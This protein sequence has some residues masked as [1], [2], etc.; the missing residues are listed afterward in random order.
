MGK[1]DTAVEHRPIF[2]PPIIR[3]DSPQ[4]KPLAREGRDAPD[5]LGFGRHVVV[6]IHS[7]AKGETVRQSDCRRPR[8][9][10][11]TRP[12]RARRQTAD[13]QRS[14]TGFNPL[15][16]EG[17]DAHACRHAKA[18]D[19]VSIHSPAKGETR[20]DP[21]VDRS[22]RVSIHSPAKGETAKRAARCV[23]LGCFNPL[24]REGRDNVFLC[25]STGKELFQST[26]PRRARPL[27]PGGRM[28]AL[29][30][31]STRPRR[32]RRNDRSACSC[33]QRFQSTRPRRAR[34]A[35]H[36]SRRRTE[37]GFNPLA[38]EGR[39][40]Q[41]RV[42]RPD[43]DNVSIHSPAKGET[44][45]FRSCTGDRRFQSTRPRRAR[46]K[47]ESTCTDHSRFQSTRPRRARLAAA[48]TGGGG[49]SV[50]IHSPAKGETAR[51][52]RFAVA[53]SGFNPLAR[54][55]RDVDSV[56]DR[57]HQPHVSI[58]SPAKGETQSPARLAAFSV[59]QSTRP[60]RARRSGGYQ[61]TAK[62]LVSIHSPAKGETAW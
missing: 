46:R 56:S 8:L 32:A 44:A 15:A 60:R 61:A 12:R 25:S 3:Q 18:T 7:P 39:D 47:S 6:S 14:A 53:Q 28:A 49:V 54:E 37:H 48:I 13:R 9:F 1:R 33:R 62:F 38:R 30:F 11:S 31:Q 34:P 29:Q 40:E 45:G 58:H 36:S 20:C 17:R 43:S 41:L 2:L 10:Q 55:G 21:P 52:N 24:A 19:T 42:L 51:K 23:C 5:D 22:V 59:F 50:S 26:R 57:L 35:S 27:A 4:Q 16:R